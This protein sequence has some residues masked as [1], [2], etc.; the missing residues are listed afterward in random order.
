MNRRIGMIGAAINLAGVVLFALS[1]FF[2]FDY[3]GFLSSSIIAIGF[4]VMI[5]AFASFSTKRTKAAAYVAMGFAGAYIVFILIVYF[6]QMT[7]VRFQELSTEAALILDYKSFDLMFTYDLLGYGLMALATFF[8]GFTIEANNKGDIVLKW[9]L[10]IHGIFAVTCFVSPLLHLFTAD[11]SSS[12][13]VGTIAL[14]FWCFYFIPIGI[15]SILHF[16]KKPV[17]MSEIND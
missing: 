12:D 14:E 10:W 1:L 13:I 5:A 3:G 6:A 7:T 4:L 8:I 11:G 16:K 2:N 17:M 9:L 15:L